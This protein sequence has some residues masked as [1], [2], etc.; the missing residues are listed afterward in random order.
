MADADAKTTKRQATVLIDA[1]LVIAAKNGDR[2]AAESLAHRW[3][4]RLLRTA[5]RLLG[6]AALA[7]D[8]VQ[9]A[10]I[11]IARGIGRL[12]DPDRFPA[13]SFQIL[14]RPCVHPISKRSKETYGIE[15]IGP[16]GSPFT[17]LLKPLFIQLCQ[18]A[19]DAFQSLWITYRF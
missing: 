15:E 4:P 11:S 14:H 2:A 8:V 3:R 16:I 17:F 9:E 1:Y 6:D 12:I 10:W 13:F 7:E 5:R 19:L 18:I